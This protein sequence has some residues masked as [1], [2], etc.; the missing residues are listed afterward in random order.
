MR[1]LACIFIFLF[2]ASVAAPLSA[3]PQINPVIFTRSTITILSLPKPTE[4]K[5]KADKD[6]KDGD[7]KEASKDENEKPSEDRKSVV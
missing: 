4:K 5:E 6:K 1:F 3:Q 2:S 7:K